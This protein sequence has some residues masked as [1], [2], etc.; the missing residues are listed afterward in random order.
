[1]SAYVH[2]RAHVLAIVRT[3]LEG[4]SDPRDVRPDNVWHG[5]SWSV[6][7]PAALAELDWQQA[8]KAWRRLEHSNAEDVARLLYD[9]NVSSVRYRYADADESGM[10]PPVEP[11][12]MRDVTRARRLATT[13]A[14][15]ALSSLEYQSCEHPEWPTS[16]GQRFCEAFRRSLCDFL[17]RGSD[18]WSISDEINA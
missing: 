17:S 4:P 9:E 11:F 6:L 10:V 16:E 3:A 5:P 15:C 13:D 7:E 14:L 1:V 18:C 2:D 8:G 12:T